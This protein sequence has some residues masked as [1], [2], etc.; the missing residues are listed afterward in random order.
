MTE[1]RPVTT[2]A[3]ENILIRAPNWVGDIVMATG[4]FADVRRTFPG[5]RIT[6]LLEPGRE[7]ILEGSHD[8]D[9]ILFD[10]AGTSPAKLW[11]IA[12]ELRKERFDLAIIFPNSF[13]TALVCY[14]AGIPRRAGYR[15]NLRSL[16]LSHGVDYERSPGGKRRPVPMPLFYAKLCEAAGVPRGDLKPRLCVTPEC[17]EK[18]VALRRELGIADGEP[19]VGLNPGASFGASKLWPPGHFAELGDALTEKHGHRTILFVGPGEEAI[20]G[21]IWSRMRHK[22]IYDRSRLVPLDVLKPFVRDLKLLVTTDTG[23][24]HYAVAFGVPAVVIMGP[25]HPDYTAFNLEKTEVIRHDVPCGPCHLK[26]CPIDHRCMVG[27]TPGEVMGRIEEIDR[28]IA[29]FR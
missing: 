1:D 21:E 10:R 23:P 28:R 7:K 22:P 15:R 17:E 9:R 24:R 8:F 6:V 25:T 4:N 18:A 27:I 2:D 29:V 26:V 13:R 5:A 11:R 12:R 3:P 20:A 19:L 16:L 14:L